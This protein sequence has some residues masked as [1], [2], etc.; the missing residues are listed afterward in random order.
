MEIKNPC[1]AS[2]NRMSASGEGYHC[3]TCNKCVIDFRDKTVEEIKATLKPGD[4]G[5]FLPHQLTHQKR[6]TGF[7]RMAFG[8][9]VF[10]ASLGFNVRPLKAQT[11]IPVQ[12]SSADSVTA[13][14]TLPPIII[15]ET[16][17]VNA[18]KIRS[19]KNS[20]A[21]KRRWR[22]FRRKRPHRYRTMGCPDF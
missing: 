6:Y 21:T 2:L 22:I 20:E 9:L 17:M 10:C 8:I 12:P 16:V 13:N 15:G 1:P 14:D 3:T 18:K 5:V 7:R 4:C 19:K 11:D